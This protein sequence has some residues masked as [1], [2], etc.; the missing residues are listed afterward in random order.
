MSES[1]SEVPMRAGATSRGERMGPQIC[2]DGKAPM[3][4]LRRWNFSSVAL[5]EHD[6]SGRDLMIV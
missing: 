6:G 2:F 5:A 4:W 3:A 1:E